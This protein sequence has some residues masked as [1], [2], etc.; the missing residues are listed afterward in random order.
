MRT[1]LSV[2]CRSTVF[3]EKQ[4]TTEIEELV[5]KEIINKMIYVS[6]VGSAGWIWEKPHCI[7]L[8]AIAK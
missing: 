8:I 5:Q 1:R 3:L 7:Y 2:V 4:R 6:I